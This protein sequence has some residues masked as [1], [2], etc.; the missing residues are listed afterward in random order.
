M[1]QLVSLFIMALISLPNLFS[2]RF[3]IDEHDIRL[4][5]EDGKSQKISWTRSI[6]GSTYVSLA[7]ITGVNNTSSG[8]LGLEISTAKDLSFF[9][10]N[11]KFKGD[12]I[13]TVKSYSDFAFIHESG[14]SAAHGVT[15]RNVGGN[16]N[17]WPFF[18]LMELET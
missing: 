10:D 2:Q 3:Q 13:S 12:N 4:W 15:F 18:R 8:F 6:G 16:N 7:S 9:A 14:S 11:I 17:Y 1:K 5:K